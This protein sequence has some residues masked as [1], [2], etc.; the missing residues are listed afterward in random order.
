MDVQKEDVRS[1]GTRSTEV[2]VNEVEVQVVVDEAEVQEVVT[3][4][5]EVQK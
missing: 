5:V 1:R 3:H 4:K 2:D